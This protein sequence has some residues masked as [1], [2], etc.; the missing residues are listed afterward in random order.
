MAVSATSAET[1]GGS[2]LMMDR[3]KRW[4][5]PFDPNMSDEDVFSLL[6][7]P[8]FSGIDASRFPAAAPFEG[9]LKN[10]CRILRFAPGDIIVREGDYG[11][12]AFLVL[13]G[14]ARVVFQGGLPAHVLG[15][16]S[17]HRRGWL[18][19][20]LSVLRWSPINE[21]RDTSRYQATQS[22]VQDAPETP[23]LF[24]VRNPGE[25]FKEAPSSDPTHPAPP[26]Q[27][28]LKSG[29]FHE[30][31][32]FGVIAA[33]GRVRRT[34]TIYAETPCEVL[35]MRWQALRD[36]KARDE[37]WNEIIESSYRGT[38]LQIQINDHPLFRDLDPQV[39]KR[40]VDATLNETYGSFEW[41]VGFKDRP[42][43]VASE[44]D[45]PLVNRQGDYPDGLLLVGGGFGRVA[46][47]LSHGRRTIEYLREGDTY[48]LDELYET[49][50]SG[51]V[52]PLRTTLTA[53]GYMHVMRVPYDV[54]VEH[55]F[56]EMEPPTQSLAD[57]A[58]RPFADDAFLEWAVQERFIN[59]TRTM[60]IDTER[61]VR[62]D[63]C[64]R[65]CSR[66]HNGNP[67]F[68]R[69]GKSLGH[70]MVANACMHCVDPVCMIG[71]P[72]GAIHRSLDGG[73]VIINDDSC[74]GCGT[75]AQ[76]C[77]YDNIRLVGIQDTDGRPVLDPQ[78]QKPIL[79][80]TKC[81]LCEG[82][83]G[84]PSCARAC[85]HDALQRVDLRDLLRSNEAG[86]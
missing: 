76:S 66:T 61:C 60:L 79:K 4:D 54:L 78:S 33:L 70:W 35:E 57:A 69:H 22:N 68:L 6:L 41:H 67:R 51:Q 12:S 73:S 80:A 85:P 25:I 55:V 81:D 52:Q 77:P 15:R 84:G 27:D 38:Q 7:R 48:G 10:D 45:E 42:R 23:S 37:S 28:H 49:W 82:H 53:L 50:K 59:G 17:T 39:R 36:I 75:C 18:R 24:R 64:V 56:P 71:C 11:N 31:A 43:G 5:K 83:P 21:M 2:I 74:I 65:A 19:S 14:D 34:A 20:L 26:L 8:E 58:Q 40:I 46:V 72:T 16:Q 44:K 13:G 3:P 1:G 32:L 47:E 86:L 63:D 29:I 30:G 62:C 9:I